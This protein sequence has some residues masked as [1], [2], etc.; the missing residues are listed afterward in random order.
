MK[1]REKEI[2]KKE[3][4]N[5]MTIVTTITVTI[6]VTVIETVTAVMASAI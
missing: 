3:N 5:R 2:G 1:K 4:R 6:A